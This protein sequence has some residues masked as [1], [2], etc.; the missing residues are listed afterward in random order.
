MSNL[1]LE[2][3][4]EEMPAG[5]IASA[6]EQLNSAVTARLHEVRLG[7]SSVE[8]YGTP[9]RLIVHATGLPDRQPDVERE[10]RGPAKSVAYGPDGAPTGAAIGFARKQGVTVESLETIATPQGEYILARFTE[11]GKPAGEVLGALLA[12]AVTGLYF[13]K[14]M[15]WGGAGM[16]FVRPVRWIL[17]LLDEQVVPMEIGGVHSGRASRGHRFLAPESFDVSNADQLLELLR[18]AYVMVD[19]EE[20]R[21][22]IREQSDALAR[23]AGGRIP[24][25]EGLLDENVWL[26]EWPTAVL[27]SFDAAYLDLPRPVLVTAMKKHQRYFPVEGADGKLLPSFIAVRSG[28][29]DYLD[30][31]REGYERVLTAR[32][33]DAAY[34]HKLDRE[35]SLEEMTGQLGRLI[36]QDRLGTMADKRERLI[37][38]ASSFGE[39]FSQ[40]DTETTELAR[41]ADLCKADLV[42]RMVIE[43]PALQGIMG[44]EYA[45]AAGEPPAVAE[46][47]AEHY[48]PRSAGDAIPASRLGQLLALADRID[49]LTG[50]LGIG[51]M[52]SG[53]SDPYGLRRAAQGVVQLLSADNTSPSPFALAAAASRAYR[54]VNGLEL[55]EELYNNLRTLFSQRLDAT[56]QEQGVRYD[57]AEAVL[58]AAGPLASVVEAAIARAQA[59]HGLVHDVRFVPTVQAAARVSNILKT[60]PVVVE[61]EVA[62]RPVAEQVRQYLQTHLQAVDRSRFEGDAE[63]MLLEAVQSAIPNTAELAAASN[64]VGLFTVLQPLNTAVNQFFDDVMVMAENEDVRKNRLALLGAVEALYKLLADWTKIVVS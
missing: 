51:T 24:W 49:T 40:S 26:V 39:L 48:Q 58:N 44:R 56:L 17:C 53:S 7:A 21:A 9:R 4:T 35:T 54:E 8:V 45:L 20:R 16:R 63:A 15:R 6:L 42:S 25:D 46:A 10:A 2:V 41:A 12:D 30:V 62:P 29:S 33:S 64:Y 38:L 14:L 61:P 34:F 55:G 5:A 50:Y 1:I 37:R 47:I 59:M 27:G 32:F 36:F 23:N 3:G 52:P 57:V 19:P 13:P 11:Q 31:V 28:G 43:L 18:K 60:P 22:N